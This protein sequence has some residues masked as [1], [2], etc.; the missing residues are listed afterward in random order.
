MF[1]PTKFKT[2]CAE[3]G[4][5]INMGEIVYYSKGKCYCSQ[6]KKYRAEMGKQQL[7][8]YSEIYR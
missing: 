7:Y 5:F 6:S 3:T 2:R 4:K 8:N 1:F